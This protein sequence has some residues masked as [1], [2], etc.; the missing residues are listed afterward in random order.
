[1]TDNPIETEG[2]EIGLM[3]EVIPPRGNEDTPVDLQSLTSQESANLG[4][5][6]VNLG[7]RSVNFSV[8]DLAQTLQEARSPRTSIQPKNK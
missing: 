1:M 8:D 7:D 6:H 4:K 5:G 2:Q 3:G